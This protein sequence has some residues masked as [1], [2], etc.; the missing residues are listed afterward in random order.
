[1]RMN[2]KLQRI[3][4]TTPQ[5]GP[6]GRIWSTGLHHVYVDDKP[7]RVFVPQVTVYDT[8]QKLAEA[9]NNGPGCRFGV[10][11]LP[12]SIYEGNDILA[13]MNLHDVG[14]VE[15][16]VYDGESI[17]IDESH[18]TNLEIK[19][20]HD[21][22]ELPAYSIVGK[23][24]ASPCPSE[25]ADYVLD[26]LVI[27]RVD[28]VEEGGCQ[29]CTTSALPGEIILTSKK[30]YG[31]DLE[32]DKVPEQE[33]QE[34]IED[35]TVVEEAS[36][37]EAGEAPE[38]QEQDVEEDVEDVEEVEPPKEEEEGGE[39]QP[40]PE[41]ED[42]DESDNPADEDKPE[43]GESEVMGIIKELQR[44]IRE[45][46]EM[47]GKRPPIT[48]KSST[49]KDDLVEQ[50]IRAGKAL[51]AQREP[52]TIMAEHSPEAFKE[53]AAHLSQ[54]VDFSAKAKLSKPTPPDSK[55]D[56]GPTVDEVLAYMKN[57]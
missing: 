43:D 44:E 53:Y 50:L 54:S 13:K 52:L 57:R 10:D 24:E 12:Q 27:E 49:N 29:V 6:Q 56:E 25:R 35:V 1:M 18:L 7:A 21:S 37:P 3:K 45:L 51:P 38:T 11:H 42:E 9:V 20:L 36:Q 46:R 23:M 34:T 32:A 30:S 39:P 19:R 2:A 14:S 47:G 4:A 15:R 16:V 41:K 55:G 5:P 8:F 40:E 33:E 48:A 28:F 31:N 22:G 26:K 17:Y